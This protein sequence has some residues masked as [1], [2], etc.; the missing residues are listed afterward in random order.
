M[1]AHCF[2]LYN[3]NTFFKKSQFYCARFLI[4][5]IRPRYLPFSAVL[6]AKTSDVLKKKLIERNVAK[7]IVPCD[8][9]RFERSA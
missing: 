4:E 5:F 8:C 7:L 2:L 9:R 6:H 3:H 1:R